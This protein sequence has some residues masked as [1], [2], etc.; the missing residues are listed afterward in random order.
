MKSRRRGAWGGYGR[1]RQTINR[2]PADEVGGHYL[3]VLEQMEK[4]SVQKG[5]CK[6]FLKKSVSEI[7]QMTNW[8]YE[9]S[10]QC[11]FEESYKI[12][13]ILHDEEDTDEG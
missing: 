9:I 3:T 2:V 7:E 1:G 10:S 6:S 12:W 4:A 13:K 11:S 5:H 8:E